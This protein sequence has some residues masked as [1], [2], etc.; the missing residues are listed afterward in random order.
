[1][2]K[3]VM[4]EFVVKF[5][6][7]RHY[8]K[9]NFDKL[10][11]Y[12]KDFIYGIVAMIFKYTAGIVTLFFIFDI[13]YD[14]NGWSLYQILFMYGL[15]LVGFS[16]WSCFFIN[17]ITL[18]YYIRDGEFERFLLRPV[19]PIFQIMMD[20]F[21]EDSWGELIVGIVILGFAWHRLGV[22]VWYL[23]FV[24]LIALSACFIY[25]GMSIILSTVSFY[26]VAQADVANL[27]FD[28]KELAQYP[29]TIY[30]RAFQ[31]IFTFLCPVAFVA[32]VPSLTFF[33]DIPIW[34]VFILPVIS[35][36]YYHSA[37][38]IWHYGL[39]CYSGVGT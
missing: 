33:G 11:I 20:G 7:Y 4:S 5:G 28:V 3:A 16:L 29:I 13:V 37:K 23:L 12:D 19:D 10:E 27:T 22:P 38:K 24:P 26:T 35:L 6:L 9:M 34:I 21:D 1:M 25:A 17:T 36:I 31:F 14:I 39:R 2:C 32:F 30:P 18:P 8:F 15:N